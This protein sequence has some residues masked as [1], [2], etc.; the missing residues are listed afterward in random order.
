MVDSGDR[1]CSTLG[2]SSA[3]GVGFPSGKKA[4]FTA[5]RVSAGVMY[6]TVL[7]SVALVESVANASV[8]RCDSFNPL[9]LIPLH[10]QFLSYGCP[11]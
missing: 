9:E 2:R 1:F 7:L 4:L 6:P 8:V 5:S 3:G 11:S 10:P